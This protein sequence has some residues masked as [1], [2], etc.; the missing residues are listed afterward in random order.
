MI[1]N[2]STVRQLTQIAVD[3]FG[4]SLPA[5]QIEEF[6]YQVSRELQFSAAAA[7]RSDA[8]KGRIIVSVLGKN[9]PGIVA[10]VSNVLAESGCDIRDINQTLV[11]DNF[12]MIMLVDASRASKSIA[13][14][15]DGLRKLGEDIGVRIYAQHEDIFTAM[16]RI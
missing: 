1:L 10:S 2:R 3:V 16:Q 13:E 15:K 5:S 4:Q 11:Q 6:I 12:A 14:L 9:R 8:G 7:P